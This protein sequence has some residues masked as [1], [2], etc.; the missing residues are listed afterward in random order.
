[1][2]LEDDADREAY[3]AQ[4]ASRDNTGRTTSRRSLH[5]ERGIDK[6]DTLGESK[7]SGRDLVEEGD[8]DRRTNLCGAPKAGILRGRVCGQNCVSQ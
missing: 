3:V 4:W 7:T 1:M 8:L 2:L 5:V 6:E